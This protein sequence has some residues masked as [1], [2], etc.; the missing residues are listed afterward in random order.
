VTRRARNV[1]LWT[2]IG[3]TAVA[4][5]LA[6][7]DARRIA[8]LPGLAALEG[9]TIDARF[10]LRG[11]R[12]PGTDRI[13]IVG[14]DDLLRYEYP[15][16]L[17]TRR[18]YAQLIDEI[19]AASPKLIV[20]DL[21]FSSPEQILPPE[22]AVRVRAAAAQLA[23]A[24]DPALAEP[25]DVLAAVA[26]ELRGDELLAQAI[27]RS[28]R[29]MLG[30]NFV[31][32][33][34]AP[35]EEIAVEPPGL[36]RARLG[37]VADA[38]GGDPNL[39]PIRATAVRFSL[40]AIAQG[41]LGAGAINDLRDDDGVRRRMP[42]VLEYGG[43]HYMTLGLAAALYD[44]GQPRATR[45]VAGGTPLPA[46]GRALPLSAAA[47]LPLDVL[48]RDRIPRVSAADVIAPAGPARARAHA[49]LAGKLV[50]VGHTYASAD[51]VATPL[52]L[53]A[54]GVE[55]HATVAEN[56]LADR[57]L[58]DPGWLAAVAAT[59]VLGGIVCA[60]QL[61]R[62]RRRA[63]V[64]PLIA[65]VAL[66]GY[67]GIALALF[68]RGTVIALALPMVLTG[69]VLLAATI[70]GLAT[71]GREKLHLRSLFSQYVSRPV[72]DRILADPAR[73]RLGGERKELTVLFADI[74]GFSQVAEGMAPEELA[75][76]LGE[77][78]TPMTDLVLASGGTLDKY[79]GD[80]IMAFWG[81][82]IDMPDHAARAC[83]VALQMQRALAALNRAWA[84]A[85]RAPIAIGI[86]LNTGPMAVG[87]MGSAARFEYTVLGD[88]VNLASRLEGLTKEYGVGIL[89]GE[90][91]ARAAGAGFGF[92]EI[93]LVRV[94]GRAGAAPVF[95]LVGAGPGPSTGT[96]TGAGAAPAPAF[97]S[98]LALYRERRF[99]EAK[100][101]FAAQGGDP[102][103]A[104]MAARCEVLAAAPPPP[105]WDGVYDQR[106][107]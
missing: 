102:A 33:P 48:G 25:R 68:A 2:A 69:A 89:V 96:G 92:R 71:E 75:A 76:F 24:T 20:L 7:V 95:E 99:D 88:Q 79:I 45:Y 106:S 57:V 38:G 14:M 94:K 100:A 40:P 31:R 41:A 47:S 50:F 28:G 27:A 26:E 19:S 66:A 78:L 17:Q 22:L 29:V 39:R 36:A 64:P 56:L 5:V 6:L 63:W 107:K 104:V 53:T 52:D 93:D 42:L 72:V 21:F 44:L 10:R 97:A 77:Y 73:A 35:G 70:G 16:V 98:A 60:A 87:N 3:A 23:G 43:R 51:K 4:A 58:R 90:A 37:E 49:Q 62:V 105:D 59:L 103:A 61:R 32:G 80:A 8:P 30:A 15:G 11:S 67:A 1:P 91:T 13:V 82:P 55:L 34:L 84:Q 65:L 86:G 85:G 9:L 101:A 12:A 81:A 83:E 54:D 74:R 46:A 18:G